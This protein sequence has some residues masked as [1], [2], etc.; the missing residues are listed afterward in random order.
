MSFSLLIMDEVLWLNTLEHISRWKPHRLTEQ[1]WCKWEQMSVCFIALYRNRFFPLLGSCMYKRQLHNTLLFDTSL[2]C[3]SSVARSTRQPLFPL[4]QSSYRDGDGAPAL[5]PQP[6]SVPSSLLMS[7]C[8][9]RAAG[10]GAPRQQQFS[11]ACEWDWRAICWPKSLIISTS[12]S[13]GGLVLWGWGGGER[14]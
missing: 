9:I 8:L 5:A 14:K 7:T 6:S 12:L 3:P 13:G 2:W 10:W 11:P 4:L 1:L